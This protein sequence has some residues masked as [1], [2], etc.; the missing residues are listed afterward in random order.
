[1]AHFGPRSFLPAEYELA[2]EYT[3]LNHDVLVQMLESCE[4]EDVLRLAVTFRN[5]EDKRSL[6]ESGHVLDWLKAS[7]RRFE[8]DEVVRRADRLRGQS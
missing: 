4:E 5:D 6:A 2:H 8:F 1:M 3:F 7:G